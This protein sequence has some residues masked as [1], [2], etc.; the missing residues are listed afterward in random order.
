MSDEMSVP[1]AAAAA[2]KVNKG[3]VLN[4]GAAVVAGLHT[5]P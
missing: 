1:A 5:V 3:K 2:H 4:K